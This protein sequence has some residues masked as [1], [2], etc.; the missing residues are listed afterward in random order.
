MPASPSVVVFDVNE[1]LSDMNPMGDRFADVGAPPS[2]ARLWFAAVL[3]D[4]F[5]LTAAGDLARFADLAGD[6][7]RAVLAAEVIDRPVDE[8]VAHV[9]DGFTTLVLHPDVASGVAA[10]RAAGLRLVT[11]SNGATAVADDLLGAA[12][13]RD[14]F[15]QLLSV[16]D[17]GAWKPDRRAYEHTA[18][19][20]GAELGD[21]VLVAAH[22]WDIHGATRAGMATAWV[23]RSGAAYPSSFA[24]ATWEVGAIGELAGL[25]AGPAPG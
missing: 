5:A 10:L 16:D 7:I 17:T 9:L 11:L 3:R 12:G 25:L 24:P 18:T 21:I 19:S 15:E 4:G 20:C 13:I 6:G 23:N 1:T 8:A 14:D 2:L 22:P